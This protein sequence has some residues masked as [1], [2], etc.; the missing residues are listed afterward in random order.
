[1]KKYKGRYKGIIFWGNAF[2][3]YRQNGRG[4]KY[5]HGKI[6]HQPN[7]KSIGSK[8]CGK[9]EHQNEHLPA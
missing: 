8:S 5:W 3:L 1:M 4:R 2:L 9:I 6:E 7:G